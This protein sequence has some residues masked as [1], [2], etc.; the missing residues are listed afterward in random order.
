MKSIHCVIPFAALLALASAGCVT[1][2]EDMGPPP[3]SQADIG[4]LREEIR[5]LNAR[6]EASD[7]ELGRIQ[8]DMLSSRSS[9]PAYATASQLQSIQSQIEELQRMVRAIDA[10]RIQDK[11]EIYDDIVKKVSTLVKS[12]TSPVRT[13]SARST[14][15][16]GYEHVVQSGE[17]LSKI[18][19][20][21]GVKMSVIVDANQLKSA[22]SIFV[23]Q[24]LFIPD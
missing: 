6:I 9:Q 2:Q 1:T 17:S 18:A 11:K 4:Y 12:P 16:T 10:A 13:P 3:A 22:D 21:Y 14:S 23:G 7:S 24:K 19:A 5:R 8:G 15:Q 20:A